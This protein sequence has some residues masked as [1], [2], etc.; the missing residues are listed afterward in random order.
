MNRFIVIIICLYLILSPFYIFSSGVPQ[1]AD[2]LI[3]LGGGV[4]LLGKEFRKTIKLP[5]FKYVF[6]LLAL[7]AI[8]N[9][10]YSYIYY[11]FYGIENKM[12][13]IP[14][15]YIFN[16]LFMIMFAYVLI[17]NSHNRNINIIALFVIISLSIQF[18]LA[19]LG[20]QGGNKDVESMSRPSLFFNNPNQLG[21]YALSMIT[22]FFILESKFKKN[23][24]VL[25]FTIF[26]SSYLILYSGSRAA[27]A[28]VILLSAYVIY[29]EGFKLDMKSIFLIVVS[30]ISIPFFFQTNFVQ[31]RF[32]LIESR[33]ER[34]V[35]SGASQAEIRGY[36]RIYLNPQYLFY[37]AGEGKN[38]RFI[39]RH[40]LEIHS[41]FGTMLFSYGFLG[42][43]MF[44]HLIYYAIKKRMLYSFILLLPILVYNITHN[45]LRNSLLWAIIVSI[46]ISNE[47]K[48]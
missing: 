35:N 25:L 36:D 33:N 42:L 26:I 7:I 22:I 44:L 24:F 21:Y 11:A 6:W 34:N 43:F 13:F 29:K 1:P 16:I 20:I 39:S 12:Y 3:A 18:I 10:T 17:S 47:R 30:L 9:L 2:L 41:G 37:G 14:L 32:D 40:Q 15:Y 5:I 48:S 8:I 45:G 4:F 31:K 19:L 23:I 38:D 28:G 46:Y 27:L